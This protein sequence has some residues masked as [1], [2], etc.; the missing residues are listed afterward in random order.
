MQSAKRQRRRCRS[1]TPS[2]VALYDGREHLGTVCSVADGWCTAT[3]P[4]GSEIGRYKD[5]ESARDAILA[6][7]LAQGASGAAS[8]CPSTGVGKRGRRIAF[9]RIAAA[10]LGNC[11]AIVRRWLPDGRREGDEWSARNPRREDRRCGSFKINLRTGKWSDFA[12]GDK[13]GDLVALAA[14]LFGMSQAEAARHLA[15]MLGI[16]PYE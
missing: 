15:K 7:H 11:D 8:A 14:F 6:T 12:T 16:D 10:A 2:E 1:E 13:G 5:R 9:T 4:D 3:L